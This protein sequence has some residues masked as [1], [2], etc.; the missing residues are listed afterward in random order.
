MRD[1]KFEICSRKD[2][3]LRDYVECFEFICTY[4]EIGILH[5]Y[6]HIKFLAGSKKCTPISKCGAN[7]ICIC[8]SVLFL[9][10][11]EMLE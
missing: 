1:A 11:K 5:T 10:L 8:S 7:I 4:V 3:N 2:T 6:S 9:I